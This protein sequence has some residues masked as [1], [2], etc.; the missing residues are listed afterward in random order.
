[1]AQCVFITDCSLTHGHSEFVVLKH[2]ID[3]KNISKSERVYR[4]SLIHPPDWSPS[5]VH[6]EHPVLFLRLPQA[7]LTLVV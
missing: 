2:Y 3:S 6:F 7:S 5:G 1:M 4:I